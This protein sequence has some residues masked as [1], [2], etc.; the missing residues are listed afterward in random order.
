MFV[1]LSF[2]NILLARM[3]THTHTL[4]LPVCVLTCGR[5]ILSCASFV[6]SVSRPVNARLCDGEEPPLAVQHC[7]IPCQHYCLLTEWS[8]WGAC[9]YDSC[10]EPHGKK[11]MLKNVY[12]NE[13]AFAFEIFGSL[14]FPCIHVCTCHKHYIAAQTGWSEATYKQIFLVSVKIFIVKQKERKNEN[15][16][17]K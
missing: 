9:L 17:M 8:P 3:H 7:S 2:L 12:K 4:Q 10:E 13:Q 11:G 5:F 6:C 14:H 15:K 1:W 16:K